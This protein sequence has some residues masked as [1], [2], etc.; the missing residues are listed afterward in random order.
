MDKW[1]DEAKQKAP[2]T[3]VLDNLDLV[4]GPENEVRTCQT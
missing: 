2:C 4:L 1:L 3:L